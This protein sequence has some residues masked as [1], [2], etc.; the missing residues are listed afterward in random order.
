MCEN[1]G[2]DD[3]DGIPEEI[4]DNQLHSQRLGNF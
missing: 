1:V 4:I 3:E 2:L